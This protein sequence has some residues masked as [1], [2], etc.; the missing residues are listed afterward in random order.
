LGFSKEIP[1]VVGCRNLLGYLAGH[2]RPLARS[3]LRLI[4][5][6]TQMAIPLKWNASSVDS[7]SLQCGAQRGECRKAHL[8][9]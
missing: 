9:E 3:V 2:P 6:P 4:D 8:K 5:K 1:G 7:W